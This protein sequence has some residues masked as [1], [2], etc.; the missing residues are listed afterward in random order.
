MK[1]ILLTIVIIA[2][3]ATL[4]FS[5][6]FDSLTVI[7]AEYSIEDLARKGDVIFAALGEGGVMYSTDEGFTWNQTSQ[8]PDAGFGQEAANSIYVASNGDLIV[9]GNLNYNGSPLEGVVFRSSDNGTSWNAEPYD[10]LGGYEKSKKIIELPNGGLMMHGGQSKLFTSSLSNS[11]WTQITAPGGVIF[12]FEVIGDKVFVVTNPSTGT[13]GT[14][15]SSDFGASWQRY[16]GNGTPVSGGTVTIAPILSTTNYKYIGIG[17]A[18]GQKGVFRSGIN[19]TLWVES[20]NGIENFGVYPICMATDN[21][22]IWMV[23]QDAGGGCYFTST[24]DFAD[25][26]EEPVMGLPQQGVGGPCVRK[27]MVF[28]THLYTYANKSIYRIA[29]VAAPTSISEQ[30]MVENEIKVYPNPGNGRINLEFNMENRSDIELSITDLSGRLVFKQEMQAVLQ[31]KRK[32]TIDLSE[33][34]SGLYI[35]TLR[36]DEGIGTSRI[37]II[38]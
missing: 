33:I 7:N 23:F 32:V 27:M 18:Y 10:G 21:Q 12:G 28:K 4:S 20:I 19:D 35:V 22:T 8:L 30:S 3:S 15:V 11:T 5:Q 26:W 31:G 9:G 14:W 2:V 24:T 34:K 1:K 36:S 29:D 13:A 38:K 6:V 16:G 25:N 17:G 37:N